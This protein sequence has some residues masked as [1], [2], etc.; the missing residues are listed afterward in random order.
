MLSLLHAT[1]STFVEDGTCV[2]ITG[3]VCPKGTFVLGWVQG[4]DGTM[5]AMRGLEGALSTLPFTLYPHPGTASSM[6]RS[7]TLA[8][9]TLESPH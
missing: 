6:T 9:T 3:G 8:W 7:L 1:F 5:N 2:A 4:P